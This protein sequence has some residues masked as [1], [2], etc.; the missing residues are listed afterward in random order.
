M[1]SDN[2]AASAIGLEKLKSGSPFLIDLCPAGELIPSLGE[3][4]FLH[5]GP[6]LEG[7]H[8]ACGSGSATASAVSRGGHS[9]PCPRS[10][11][12]HCANRARLA[13]AIPCNAPL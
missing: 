5:A 13:F 1:Q 8:E 2:Q 12:P 3:R 7:C 4:D 11:T 9:A 6:P 10:I